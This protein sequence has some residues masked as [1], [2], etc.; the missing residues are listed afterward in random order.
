VVDVVVS[1]R[2]VG[3]VVSRRVVDVVVS[4]SVVGAG[5]EGASGASRPNNLSCPGPITHV[6]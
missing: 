2:V 1:G 3:V 6:Q 5:L 4:E